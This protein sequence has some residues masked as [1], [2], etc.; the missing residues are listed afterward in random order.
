MACFQKCLKTGER[1]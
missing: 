1:V